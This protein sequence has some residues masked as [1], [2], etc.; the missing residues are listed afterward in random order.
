MLNKSKLISNNS[1]KIILLKIFNI[2]STNF[3]INYYPFMIKIINTNLYN[4][5]SNRSINYSNKIN[6]N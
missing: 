2:K 4:I 1:S 3:K 6:N 5:N